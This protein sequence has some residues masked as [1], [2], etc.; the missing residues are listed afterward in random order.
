[1]FYRQLTACSSSRLI[2]QLPDEVLVG[3]R[4]VV[5]ELARSLKLIQRCRGKMRAKERP[6]HGERLLLR[7]ESWQRPDV[8]GRARF[9]VTQDTFIVTKFLRA[10][11][12]ERA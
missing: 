2:R 11:G 9:E 4:V 12:R 7:S 5:R 6:N 10:I 1:M 3:G 8:S